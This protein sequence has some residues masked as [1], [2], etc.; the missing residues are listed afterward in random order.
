MNC[1]TF[2]MCFLESLSLA[3]FKHFPLLCIAFKR[4][5]S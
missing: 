4:A 2:E 1:H 3:D 5:I